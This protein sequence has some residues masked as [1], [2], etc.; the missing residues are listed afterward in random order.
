MLSRARFSLLFFLISAV[1]SAQSQSRIDCNAM[2]SKILKQEVRYCV[3]L[4]SGYDG[5][6]KAATRYPVLYFLHGLGDNE[7]TLFNSGGWTLLDDLRRQG[8]MGDFLIVAPEGRRSF[9][10]NSADNSARYND[11]FLRE[12][13]SHIDN[14]YRIR[15]GR[16]NRA[17]SGVSM[18]GYGALRFAF[19]HPEMFSAVSAQSAALITASPAELDQ[20]ERSGAPLARVLAAVFGSPIQAAHWNENSPFVLAKRNA[21]AVRKLEIYFNCGQDDNYGFEAG[22]AALHDL[23]Q[24]E[25]IKHKYHLYPGD[26]TL[27]Y[28]LSHFDEVLEFHSRAFGRLREKPA[29]NMSR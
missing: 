26:H 21:V 11:F 8:K 24:K 17:I 20:T 23:L 25:G 3:Y 4:P 5:A 28:F 7:Q 22:A 2:S 12:F 27:P 18:G 16:N 15:P 6:T 13:V 19:A 29:G 10:I 1:V 9:Y 14:H